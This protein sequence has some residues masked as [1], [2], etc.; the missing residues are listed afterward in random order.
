MKGT[1]HYIL[2]IKFIFILFVLLATAKSSFSQ[3]KNTRPLIQ[4]SGILIDSDSL[5]PLP[6][7]S[8]M[9]KNTYRGTISDYYGFFS[10][11]AQASDTV[12]FSHVGYKDAYFVI[13]DTL[14]ITRYSIIQM[15]QPDTFTIQEVTVY[16][17]PTKEQFRD[18]FLNLNLPEDDYIRASNNLAMAEL[19]KRFQAT[20]LDA[21]GNFKYQMQLQQTKLYTS[22]QFPSYTILNPIAWAQ[23][24]DAWK[25]G[26]FKKK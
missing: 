19:Q 6:F 15:L 26:E 1:S 11:V 13:P 14:E 2:K 18:A 4:F 22:G 20:P 10:F 17:W 3:E 16:P 7:A 12:H 23:F 21:S 25:K 9:I 5:L 8:I 24:I